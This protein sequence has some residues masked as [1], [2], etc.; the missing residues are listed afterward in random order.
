MLQLQ[1]FESVGLGQKENELLQKSFSC[2]VP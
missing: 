1:N 2:P